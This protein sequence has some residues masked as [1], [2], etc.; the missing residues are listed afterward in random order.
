MCTPP[1]SIV[2]QPFRSIINDS[3]LQLQGEHRSRAALSDNLFDESRING[4]P[5]APATLIQ[6]NSV[7]GE[8]GVAKVILNWSVVEW[9]LRRGPIPGD[10]LK[11]KCRVK[12]RTVMLGHAA[13]RSAL[14][15]F[16]V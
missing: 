4:P 3:T 2:P 10:G 9:I 5:P 11:G 16:G 6:C 14:I 7:E 8:R 1:N 13:T 15:R 12:G